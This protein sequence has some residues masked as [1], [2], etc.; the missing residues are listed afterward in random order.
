MSVFL[1]VPLLSVLVS[2]FIHAFLLIRVLLLVWFISQMH[3][4]VMVITDAMKILHMSVLV[5]QL[6]KR[7]Q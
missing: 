6:K 3:H 4:A 2:C 1:D 5:T 7:S